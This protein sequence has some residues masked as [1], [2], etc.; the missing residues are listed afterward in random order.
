[1]NS[2]DPDWKYLYNLSGGVETINRY[3]DYNSILYSM[4]S[5]YKNLKFVKNWFIVIQSPSQIPYFLDLIKVNDNEY[6]LNYKSENISENEKIKIHFIYH[7]DI[8]KNETFLTTFNSN[9]IVTALVFI[10]T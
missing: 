10:K 7:N 5:V 2:S 1:M 9:T 8:F 3:R 4:R 6:L